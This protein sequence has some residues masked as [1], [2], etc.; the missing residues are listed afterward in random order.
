MAVWQI[1][2]NIFADSSILNA[3]SFCEASDFALFYSGSARFRINIKP[4][5][6]DKVV[7][8]FQRTI[9]YLCILW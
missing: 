8:P 7:L 2:L 5:I 9:R 4:I 6:S 1:R 3:S